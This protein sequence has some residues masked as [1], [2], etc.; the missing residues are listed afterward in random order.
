LLQLKHLLRSNKNYLFC[1]SIT[2]KLKKNIM[3]L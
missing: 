1:Y 3:L 2:R